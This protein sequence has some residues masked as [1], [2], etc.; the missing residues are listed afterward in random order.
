MSIAIT[1]DHQALADTAADFLARH[2]SLAAGRALLEGADEALPAFW[3]DLCALGWPGLHVPEEHGGSGYGLPELLVVVEEL[4]AALTPGPFV[5]GAVVSAVLAT[6][7]P[8]ETAAR[9]LPGLAEGSR[10]CAF[11]LDAYVAVDAGHA[12]G[13]A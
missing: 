5:P 4:G 3:G 8:N 12:A 6:A 13:S 1:A 7:L 2:G 9:L 11:A 10:P